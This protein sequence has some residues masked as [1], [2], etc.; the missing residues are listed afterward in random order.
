MTTAIKSSIVNVKL[1]GGAT[2]V[3]QGYTNGSISQGDGSSA[4]PELARFASAAQNAFEI[5]SSNMAASLN[6]ISRI[7]GIMD[8][9]N[10]EEIPESLKMLKQETQ[11][12]VQKISAGQDVLTKDLTTLENVQVRA[13]AFDNGVGVESQEI[14]QEGY[15]DILERAM[16]STPSLNSKQGKL[17]FIAALPQILTA[18]KKRFAEEGEKQFGSAPMAAAS[19]CPGCAGCRGEA[20]DGLVKAGSVEISDDDYGYL[21]SALKSGVDAGSIKVIDGYAALP[22][23]QGQDPRKVVRDLIDA[24][25]AKEAQAKVEPKVSGSAMDNFLSDLFSGNPQ[26][27]EAP[28][29]D[30]MIARRFQAKDKGIE[31]R[32]P[33]SV[34]QA[35]NLLGVEFPSETVPATKAPARNANDIGR[36]I[37]DLLLSTIVNGR[38]Q[39]PSLQPQ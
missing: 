15:Q 16:G 24:E 30:G 27:S 35:L 18:L 12:K 7:D 1:S 38:R 29:L 28:T 21:Q 19:E 22:I 37:V 8:I 14:A 39:G 6:A 34:V 3:F 26:F 32:H 20:P 17:E 23:V 13:E 2:L 36:D 25:K 10:P 33:E 5:L 31:N 9:S 11:E 4:S